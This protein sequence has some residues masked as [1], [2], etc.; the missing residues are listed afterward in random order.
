M[1]P[2][3]TPVPLRIPGQF[4]ISGRI[5]TRTHT[6]PHAEELQVSSTT[7]AP[8]SIGIEKP[9][10]PGGSEGK[11]SILHYTS[12]NNAP[13]KTTSTLGVE[14]VMKG[15]KCIRWY[16]SPPQG[17][18]TTGTPTV[19]NNDDVWS[20]TILPLANVWSIPC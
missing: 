9:R 11:P 5:I 16:L 20:A 14:A 3:T 7:A 15:D 17:C 1:K 10:V 8:G 19:L 6:P 12:N 2:S 13:S 18:R 4:G